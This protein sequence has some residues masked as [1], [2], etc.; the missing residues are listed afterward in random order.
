MKK[1]KSDDSAAKAI[2]ERYA[3]VLGMDQYSPPEAPKK[4]AARKYLLLLILLA[5]AVISAWF[6]FR[7]ASV[8]TAPPA[9][10]TPSTDLQQLPSGS[11]SSGSSV[12]SD[13]GPQES[14]VPES[15][16]SDKG[17]EESASYAKSNESGG[18]QKQQSLFE[19]QLP[20]N[21]GS[22]LQQAPAPSFVVLLSTPLKD[23]AI[24]RARELS[25]SGNPAEV[26]LSSSGYYGVV[27]RRD[28]YEQAQA[29]MKAIAASGAVSMTPYIMSAARV[30]E[31]IYPETRQ[32]AGKE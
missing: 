2:Q 4:S 7:P 14:V 8:G 30:K 5:L 22:S 16:E 1:S 18:A 3:R 13:H 29:A 20:G 9:A 25:N 17:V 10:I 6:F 24:E 27:L 26:I 11:T 31:Y 28:T 21:S 15:R 19:P 23:K 12:K 32:E